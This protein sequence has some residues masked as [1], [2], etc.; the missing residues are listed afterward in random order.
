MTSHKYVRLIGEAGKGPVLVILRGV[1]R[2]RRSR[3]LVLAKDFR[4]RELRGRSGGR[5]WRSGARIGK[6]LGRNESHRMRKLSLI[7]PAGA[8]AIALASAHPETGAIRCTAVAVQDVGDVS[9]LKVPVLAMFGTT[10]AARSPGA[11][12]ALLPSIPNCRL[13]YVYDADRAV[14]DER[15]EAVAAALQDFALRREGYLVNA[16]RGNLYP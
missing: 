15:P 7:P 9:S 6:R 10:N 14:D 8:V 4:V 13:V 1:A 3:S 5:R 12:K 2:R 11:A 16:K